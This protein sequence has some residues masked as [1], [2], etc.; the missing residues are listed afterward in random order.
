M[1][2]LW[3][4]VAHSEGGRYDL[5]VC[6]TIRPKVKAI[7]NHSLQRMGV[8]YCGIKCSVLNEREKPTGTSQGAGKCLAYRHGVV[9]VG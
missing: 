9:T 7:G 8:K 6:T 2:E 4:C 3:F 5:E 1:K